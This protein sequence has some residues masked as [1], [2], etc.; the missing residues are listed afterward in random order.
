[1]EIIC[2]RSMERRITPGYLCKRMNKHLTIA[3]IG[4]LPADASSVISRLAEIGHSLIRIGGEEDLD[5]GYRQLI[6]AKKLAVQDCI[7]EG[8]WE[9][10]V[11]LLL[12]DA[13]L[14]EKNVAR[15]KQVVTQKLVIS[16]KFDNDADDPNLKAWFPYSRIA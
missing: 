12:P 2:R 1:N 9:A 14:N 13:D 16:M 6:K 5:K 15:I 11:V 7:K 3:L 10:D 8:C 4:P